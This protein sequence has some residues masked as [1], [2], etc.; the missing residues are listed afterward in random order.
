M[1]PYEMMRLIRQRHKEDFLDL[2]RG[3]LY[4]AI[5]RL[6]RGQLIEVVGATRE[7]R[8]PERTVYR[9]T[10]TGE[11]EVG[12]WLRR[13]L[14]KPAAEASPFIAALSFVAHLSPQEAM[15]QLE[16]RVQDLECGI[17]ALK[18]VVQ[19]LV[20][21]I[22]RLPLLE[23]E[24]AIAMRQA[25]VVWVRG[26]IEELR[27]GQLTWDTEQLLLKLRDSSSNREGPGAKKR[28][29]PADELG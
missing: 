14:S 19:E 2:K 26:L 21:R 11:S 6:A 22:G 10:D 8:R 9:I 29:E 7:G 24:Y 13:L 23:A 27:A 3:S 4:H 1:H 15:D 20:P 17:V 5:D 28:S 16:I 12:D 18:A 25:E